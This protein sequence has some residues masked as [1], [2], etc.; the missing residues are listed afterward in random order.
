[1]NV[2]ASAFP[3]DVHLF[4]RVRDVPPPGSLDDPMTPTRYQ[5]LSTHSFG[6]PDEVW[7]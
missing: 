6:A 4:F 1:L 5:T 2:P 7:R 3:L